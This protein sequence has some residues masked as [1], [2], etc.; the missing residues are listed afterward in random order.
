MDKIKEALYKK[1]IQALKG[2]I[3]N[4]EYIK[5]AND[6]YKEQNELRIYWHSKYESEHNKHLKALSK[7]SKQQKKIRMLY[8]IIKEIYNTSKDLISKKQIL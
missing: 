7:I 6:K 2:R 8:S 5:R 3:E 4:D 1:E